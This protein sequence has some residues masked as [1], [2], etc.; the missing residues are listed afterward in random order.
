MWRASVQGPERSRRVYA[1]IEPPD[2][3]RGQ[4]LSASAR[5]MRYGGTPASVQFS[6]F[7]WV[8]NRGALAKV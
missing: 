3:R 1:S 4:A 5:N 2:L 7:Y 6:V 8:L